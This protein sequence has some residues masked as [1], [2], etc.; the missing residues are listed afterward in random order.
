VRSRDLA[1][2]D[3]HYHGH[4][5]ADMSYSETAAPFQPWQEVSFS[6]VHPLVGGGPR[7]RRDYFTGA[8]WG[9]GV[10]TPEVPYN[11]IWGQHEAARIR[12]NSPGLSTLR[13]GERRSM[14]WLNGPVAPGIDPFETV[15]R[16]RDLMAVEPAGFVDDT[17]NTAD[18]YTSRF[19]NGFA[20]N[21]RVYEDDA[22]IAQSDFYF[23]GA[24]EL[25][26]E[27]ATY[28]VEFDVDNH[29]PWA[30]VSTRTQTAW[31]FRSR[32][33]A[34]E[35]IATLPLLTVDWDAD[36]D[37]RNRLEDR[38]LEFR[39]GHQPGAQAVPFRSATLEESYDD[40]A[41]WRPVRRMWRIGANR[42]EARLDRRRGGGFV[43]LR[44][45]AQDADGN[46]IS[47]R[48]TRAFAL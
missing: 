15:R 18:G 12:L 24:V 35:D 34:G 16:Y 42:W 25:F 5:D 20:T 39:L 27:A 45:R 11:F 19:P 1:R 23:F 17:G 28:R 40:G 43:S 36:V 2:V 22:L 14:S 26:K 30:G 6:H 46:A 38:W 9:Y 41:T 47:Q 37:L 44:L 3:M 4:L 31:T 33:P 48:I 13:P 29:A 32:R 7:V 21:L 10:T 8:R